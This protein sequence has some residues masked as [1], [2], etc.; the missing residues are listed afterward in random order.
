MVVLG[1]RDAAIEVAR[2]AADLA[3]ATN[4]SAGE[5]AIRSFLDRLEKEDSYR[6]RVA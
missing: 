4:D 6:T 3:K 5:T 1:N 2:R